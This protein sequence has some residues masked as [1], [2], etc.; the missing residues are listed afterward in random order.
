MSSASARRRVLV[1]ESKIELKGD[2]K[3]SNGPDPY[4]DFSFEEVGGEAVAAPSKTASRSAPTEGKET[5]HWPEAARTSREFA[6][7]A[8]D[9]EGITPFAASFVRRGK[10]Q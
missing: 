4:G 2:M 8:T 3:M 1:Q 9:I 7:D 6:A 10:G 5:E